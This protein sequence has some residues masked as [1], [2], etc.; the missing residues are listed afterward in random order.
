MITSRFGIIDFARFVFECLVVL[1]P[2][3]AIFKRNLFP[4]VS[5]DDCGRLYLRFSGIKSSY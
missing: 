4:L 5:Y 2:H 1:L 3:P